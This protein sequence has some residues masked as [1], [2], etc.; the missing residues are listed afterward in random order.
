MQDLN[1]LLPPNSGW[2]ISAAFSIN[3]SGQIVGDGVNPEGE[4]AIFLLSPVLPEPST[5]CSLSILIFALAARRRIRNTPGYS[6][7]AR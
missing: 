7:R 2:T 4:S 5:E 3:D 1:S 6:T